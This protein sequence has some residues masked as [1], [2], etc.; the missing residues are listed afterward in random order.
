MGKEFV[1]CMR[2]RIFYFIEIYDG[3][4][5]YKKYNIIREYAYIIK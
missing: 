5:S 1:C 4:K 3:F 2:D